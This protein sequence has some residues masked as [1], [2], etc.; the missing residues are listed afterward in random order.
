MDHLNDH[1]LFSDCSGKPVPIIYFQGTADQRSLWN[2]GN[3]SRCMGKFL[4]ET[5]FNTGENTR[6]CKSIEEYV[7]FWSF[8]KIIR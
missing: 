2:G 6:E 7:E 3:C 8:S 5:G 1:F 4:N